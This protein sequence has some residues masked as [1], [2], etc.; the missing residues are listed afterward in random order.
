MTWDRERPQFT[1]HDQ[2]VAEFQPI[3]CKRMT[4][5]VSA[6]VLQPGFLSD[7]SP[8]FLQIGQMTTVL[9]SSDDI[10]I[11]RDHGD[12][13]QQAHRALAQLHGA[14]A[15]FAVGEPDYSFVQKDIFP[16]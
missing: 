2:I 9:P 16:F 5:I 3:G 12:A 6:G 8:R 4:K 11:A 15:I 7:V 1:D 10:W 14:S 13:L